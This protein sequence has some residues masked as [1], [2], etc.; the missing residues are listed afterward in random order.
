MPS[1]V[2]AGSPPTTTATSVDVP[3]PSQVSTWSKPAF[4]AIIAA[5]SAPAAGPLSTVVIG[6]LIT[7]SA[8]TTPPLDVIT[9]SGGALPV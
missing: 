3:P 1:V 5:P 2:S 6:W 8:V 4:W 9:C 7:C